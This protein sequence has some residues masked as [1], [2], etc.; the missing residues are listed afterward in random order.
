VSTTVLR[1]LF[2]IALLSY[3]FS[4]EARSQANGLGGYAIDFVALNSD[5]GNADCGKAP[6]SAP[7]CRVRVAPD[8]HEMELLL[9]SGE[10]VSRRGDSLMFVYRGEAMRVWLRGGLQYPLSR[11][12]G[13]DLWTITLR[14]E[15]LDEL[16][17]SYT[18]APGDLG[19]TDLPE[20]IEWRGPLAPAGPQRV[21]VLQGTL[22]ERILQSAILQDTRSLSIYEPPAVAQ[23][24]LVGVVYAADGKSVERFAK[25]VEPLII[26]GSLPRFVLVGIHAAQG[27]RRSYEYV[28]GLKRDN[29]A[30]L[31]HEQFLMEE[32]MPLVERSYAVPRTAASRTL[33]GYSNG[34]DWAVA[35]ALRNPRAFNN[36]IALSPSWPAPIAQPSEARRVAFFIGAGTLEPNF[37]KSALEMSALFKV[38]G[39]VHRMRQGLRGH[40]MTQWEGLLPE[41]LM[42]TFGREGRAETGPLTNRPSAS[43]HTAVTMHSG[44]KKYCSGLF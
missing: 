11:V 28:F 36:V 20:P 21:D 31:A 5:S 32:V 43:F 29:A 4:A 38:H 24:P 8:V 39:V 27:Q 22:V 41:S 30:F 17:F 2:L 12:V 1:S 15:K 18:F 6:K 26:S 10:H 37:H 34:A 23:R 9:A 25:V 14:V 42:W 19:P 44:P 16:A 35:T 13:T 40:D 7:I 33:L 3:G